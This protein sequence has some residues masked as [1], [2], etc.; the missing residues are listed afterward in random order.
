MDSRSIWTEEN[1]ERLGVM[2]LAG[3]FGL[4]LSDERPTAPC[5]HRKCQQPPHKVFA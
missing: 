1:I 3:T 4:G 5:H 2:M